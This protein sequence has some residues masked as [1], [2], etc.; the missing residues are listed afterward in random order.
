M[1]QKYLIDTNVLID[2]QM[3]RLPGKVINFVFRKKEVSLQHQIN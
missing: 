2:A 1:G 3:N